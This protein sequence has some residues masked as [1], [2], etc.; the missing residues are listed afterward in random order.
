MNAHTN[1][2]TD[3]IEAHRVNRA[4]IADARYE[5][6]RLAAAALTSEQRLRLAIHL[7]DYLTHVDDDARNEAVDMLG[8]LVA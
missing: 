2:A 4:A 5:D 3:L 6:A 8:E 7:V 1:I